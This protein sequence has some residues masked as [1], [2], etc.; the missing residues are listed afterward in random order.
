MGNAP[1]MGKIDG[2][3]E[4]LNLFTRA[5]DDQRKIVSDAL[6]RFDCLTHMPWKKE[7]E[8]CDSTVLVDLIELSDFI[9]KDV[10]P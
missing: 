8:S 10:H 5:T 7:D 4:F 3:I 2:I 1:T 9:T 6:A